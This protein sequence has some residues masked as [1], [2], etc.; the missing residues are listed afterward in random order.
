MAASNYYASQVL[1]DLL[2]G[3]SAVY[4][5]LFNTSPGGG[6]TGTEV[7]GSGYA[8]VQVSGWSVPAMVSG[9]MTSQ[10]TGLIQFPAATGN[11]TTANYWALMDAQ[12]EGHLLVYSNLLSAVTVNTGNEPKFTAGQLKVTLA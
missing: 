1:T 12:T 3:G 9:V 4:V 8:R 10:N 11:W 2:S 7:S 6:N 5:A